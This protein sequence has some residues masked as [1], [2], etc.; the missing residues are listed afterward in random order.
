MAPVPVAVV[1]VEP[2]EVV[3][4]PTVVT[5]VA[6]VMQ[7]PKC[8][9]GFSSRHGLGKHQRSCPGPKEVNK[10]PCPTCLGEFDVMGIKCI[11]LLG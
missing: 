4:T 9:R 5:E 3:V 2:E 10:V 8:A 1:K 11:P 7:C 6:E